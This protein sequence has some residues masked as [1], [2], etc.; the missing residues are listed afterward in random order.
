M[1]FLFPLLGAIF[2]WAALD[3]AGPPK[4]YGAWNPLSVF[5]WLLFLAFSVRL[6]AACF[7]IEPQPERQA[8]ED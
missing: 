6:I 2:S 3:M 7:G 4:S 1:N 5:L 8:H